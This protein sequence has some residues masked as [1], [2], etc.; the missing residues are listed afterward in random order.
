MSLKNNKPKCQ[1]EKRQ[2]L[3][4]GLERL[5]HEMPNMHAYQRVTTERDMWIRNWQSVIE[6]LKQGMKASDAIQRQEWIENVK[7]YMSCK[8]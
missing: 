3:I 1:C 4:E 7:E 5:V 2:A 6:L 8:R